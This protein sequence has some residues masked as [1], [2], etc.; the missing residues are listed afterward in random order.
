MVAYFLHFTQFT[1]TVQ[2]KIHNFI[3]T[4]SVH[5]KINNF[6]FISH[7]LRYRN[8]ATKNIQLYMDSIDPSQNKNL[9]LHTL[10][11][12]FFLFIN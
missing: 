4:L 9:F 2:L 3:R 11:I 12:P 8:N 10:A 1:S 7:N 6:F 5:H